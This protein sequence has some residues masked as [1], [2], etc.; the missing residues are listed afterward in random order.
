MGALR[1]CVMGQVRMFCGFVDFYVEGL[2]GAS[3]GGKRVKYM[4]KVEAVSHPPT[5]LLRAALPLP[6]IAHSSHSFFP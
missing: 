3:R 2:R 5:F 6:I 1:A 4:H